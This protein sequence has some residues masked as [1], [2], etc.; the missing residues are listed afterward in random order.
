[1]TTSF[2]WKLSFFALK[3]PIFQKHDIF[4]KYCGLRRRG[5]HMEDDG[6]GKGGLIRDSNVIEAFR[7]VLLNIFHSQVFIFDLLC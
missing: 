6:R 1:M 4:S 2:R 5:R 3:I 7:H